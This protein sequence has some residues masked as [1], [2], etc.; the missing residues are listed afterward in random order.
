MNEGGALQR[1][2]GWPCLLL[3]MVPPAGGGATQEADREGQRLA[4]CAKWS[5]QRAPCAHRSRTMPAALLTKHHLGLD[6]VE[7]Q[8]PKTTR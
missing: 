4:G 5:Q 7:S 1:L 2:P 6:S 8:Q 3:I